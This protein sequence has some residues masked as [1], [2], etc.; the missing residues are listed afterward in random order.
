VS[1]YTNSRHHSR[2]LSDLLRLPPYG[3]EGL[4]YNTEGDVLV[5]VTAD[6][7]TST[8]C[9]KRSKAFCSPGTPNAEPWLAC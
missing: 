4:G 3:A 7:W 5:N 6:A 1:I 2:V 8:S 9:G